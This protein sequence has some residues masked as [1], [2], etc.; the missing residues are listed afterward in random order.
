[1]R[2]GVRKGYDIPT[3]NTHNVTS[4]LRTQPTDLIWRKALKRGS[5]EEVR[6]LLSENK[7]LAQSVIDGTGGCLGLHLVANPENADTATL[8]L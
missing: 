6:K 8:L 5:A 1:M 7:G 4:M 3:V 2:S